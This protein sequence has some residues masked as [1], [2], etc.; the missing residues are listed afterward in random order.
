[1]L[2]FFGT[3]DVHRRDW[4]ALLRRLRL[5]R[6]GNKRQ[7]MQILR[8]KWQKRRELRKME[9]YNP[10]LSAIAHFT[11]KNG[12]ICDFCRIVRRSIGTLISGSSPTRVISTVTVSTASAPAASRMVL[13]TLTQ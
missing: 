4:R 2:L 10:P 3:F 6:L 12:A 8:V 13:L 1:M 11:N 9:R 5:L 7:K